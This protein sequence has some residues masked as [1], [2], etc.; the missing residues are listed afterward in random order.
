MGYKNEDLNIFNK[1]DYQPIDAEF[2][3]ESVIALEPLINIQTKYNKLDSDTFLNEI[4]DSFVARA[5]DFDL[6]NIEKHGFDAKSENSKR[7]LE[8]KQVSS[9]TKTWGGT[10]ND[11]NLEKCEAFKDQK[12]YLAVAI[13]S[14]LA[15][16]EFIVYG[17]NY[18][19]GEYLEERVR[20]VANTSTRS[21]QTIAVS[22]LLN[23]F[24]FKIV[25][26]PGKDVNHV[27]KI[28]FTKFGKKSEAWYDAFM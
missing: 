18:E 4:R 6:I 5:L 27:K 15:D 21:T 22:K 14:G 17:Q 2:L 3:T 26:P 13:W 28:L 9:S 23:D 16:L 7:Y 25:V 24:G 8:V 20:H 11:T 12:T 19:I 10:F 1:G